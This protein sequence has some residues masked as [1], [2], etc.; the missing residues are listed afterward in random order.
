MLSPVKKGRKSDAQPTFH[1]ISL[2]HARFFRQLRRL[3]SLLRLVTKGVVT[4]NA[5][6]NRDETWKAIR[7]AAG[8]QVVLEFGGVLM[9]LNR[10][11]LL[12][13][14]SYALQ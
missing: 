12:L 5:Q 2:Q 14:L 11:F 6:L 7:C 10:M 13:C 3:Q 4:I 9:D 8:S 1:G